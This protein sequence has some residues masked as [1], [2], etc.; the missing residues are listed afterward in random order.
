MTSFVSPIPTLNL[1]HWVAD[2]ESLTS[3]HI[4]LINS[5]VMSSPRCLL[6]TLEMSW[7]LL[8]M[9]RQVMMMSIQCKNSSHAWR[10]E[11]P[12]GPLSHPKTPHHALL[13]S[14][15]LQQAPV[16]SLKLQHT[17]HQGW[18]SHQLL[19]LSIFCSLLLHRSNPLQM[20]V[21]GLLHWQFEAQPHWANGSLGSMGQHYHF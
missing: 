7:D 8:Q 6:E 20:F 15:R 14:Q 11:S 21:L 1:W 16:Q 9:W 19:H 4:D 10:E 18:R 17:A 3:T 13:E 12:E 2:I 5:S